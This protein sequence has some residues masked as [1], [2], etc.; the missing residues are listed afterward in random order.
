MS[1]FS[2][3]INVTPHCSVLVNLKNVLQHELNIE[4]Y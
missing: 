2:G 3:A 4:I 1:L